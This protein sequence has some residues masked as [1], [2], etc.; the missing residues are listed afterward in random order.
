[1]T[2][3]T[4]LVTHIGPL[5]GNRVYPDF[6]PPGAQAP[7]VTYQ[8]VG[9]PT[10]DFIRGVP[11]KRFARIQINVWGI[12]RN[13]VNSLMRQIEDLLVGTTFNGSAIGALI[14]RYEQDLALRGAQQDFLLFWG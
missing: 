4:D 13:Q 1:M 7:W 3:E 14:S 12:S 10:I 8:Q 6:A 5:C 2:I 11:D 9:G